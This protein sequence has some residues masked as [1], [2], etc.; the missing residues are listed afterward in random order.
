[1]KKLNDCDLKKI[2]Q[3]FKNNPQKYFL[4]K[5]IG[6]DNLV[7]KYIISTLKD[8]F[9]LDV[10]TN[11]K[12][13]LGVIKKMGVRAFYNGIYQKI[14]ASSKAKVSYNFDNKVLFINGEKYIIRPYVDD[15]ERLIRDKIYSYDISPNIFLENY[16]LVEKLLNKG[17]GSKTLEQ[18]SSRAGEILSILHS[19]DIIYANNFIDNFRLD[20]SDQKIKLTNY[21]KSFQYIDFKTTTKQNL[22]SIIKLINSNMWFDN[23]NISQDYLCDNSDYKI[24]KD[25][26]IGFLKSQELEFMIRNICDKYN[27]GIIIKGFKFYLKENAQKIIR[28]HILESYQKSSF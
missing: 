27:S 5:N 11:H 3:F 6:E 22:N 7:I 9:S 28:T 23:E 17:F 13:E 15:S 18:I 20:T 1:M 12:S 2:N 16:E 14:D 26:P 8:D 24:I 10:N 25:V 19:N 21:T 4:D